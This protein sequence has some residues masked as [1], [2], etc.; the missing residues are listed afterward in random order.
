MSHAVWNVV[1]PHLSDTRRVFAFDIAGFGLTAPLPQ[2]MP[3]T[4]PNLVAGLADSLHELG[5]ATPVDMAGNS[6]GA[7]IALE[8]ARQGMTR[9]VVAISPPGLW[10]DH[11]ARHVEY[12][13]SSLRYMARAFP[14]LLKST[15]RLSWTRELALAVPFSLGSRRMPAADALRAI[16]DLGAALGFEDT[17]DNTRDP[18]CARDISVPLTV[19]FGGRDWILT[20]G[21]RRRDALPPHTSWVERPQWGHVPMWA[22]PAGVSRLILEGTR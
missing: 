22:D 6:L 19:V 11:G 12:L 3:P 10:R 7:T 8:A 18:F 14:G 20:R 9:T 4:I 13:F 15:L 21:S 16:D 1:T 2:G 17:F 5:I